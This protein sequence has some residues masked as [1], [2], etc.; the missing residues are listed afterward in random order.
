MVRRAAR[1]ALPDITLRLTHR[2]IALTARPVRPTPRLAVIQRVTAARITA[3]PVTAA[4]R[5]RC[6]LRQHRLH[7]HL[8]STCLRLYSCQRPCRHRCRPFFPP[9]TAVATIALPVSTIPMGAGTASRVITVPSMVR[10]AARRALPD[11]TLRLTH[12]R[13][14]LTARPVRP[15]PRPAAIQRITAAQ[16]TAAPV[17]AAATIALPV[18]TI[19]M[20]A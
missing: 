6:L 4:A 18:S 8:R 5:H 7:W 3:A 1:R 20:G 15:T 12:R 19:P 9:V 11:I 10:R 14:A 2:R 17:T 13:I 16:I